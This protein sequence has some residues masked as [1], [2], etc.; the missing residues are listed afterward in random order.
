MP[1]H[2]L[3]KYQ[4]RELNGTSDCVYQ[5]DVRIVI[6]GVTIASIKPRKNLKHNVSMDMEAAAGNA[7]R[8]AIVPAKFVHA[9]VLSEL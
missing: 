6:P 2:P 3:N 7:Y 5:I 8:F 4:T 1:A 9:G